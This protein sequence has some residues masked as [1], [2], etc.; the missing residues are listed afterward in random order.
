MLTMPVLSNR[1]LLS[2]ILLASC[3]QGCVPHAEVST[4]NPMVA[5]LE[6]ELKENAGGS[7]QKDRSIQFPA[8]VF[9]Y[10]VQVTST[11]Q[12]EDAFRAYIEKYR[13]GPRR[14][15]SHVLK[16]TNFY[17]IE[18]FRGIR[19]IVVE[20]GKSE[21]TIWINWEPTAR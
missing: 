20:K 4:V 19:V 13:I 21:L 12:A 10:P 15:W 3:I 6:K 17:Y 7:G 8:Y 14:K 18:G 16:S 2:A 5:T 11:D 9:T 1:L